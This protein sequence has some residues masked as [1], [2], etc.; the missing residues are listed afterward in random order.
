M[1]RKQR[2]RR[3]SHLF[4]IDAHIPKLDVAGS[5]PVS[6][7]KRINSLQIPAS[8]CAPFVLRLHHQQTFLQLVHNCQPAF[9][10]RLRIH[11]LVDI[12]AMAKLI[13]DQLSIHPESLH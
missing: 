13:G 6:R 3:L 8:P 2:H 4:T 11:V 9:D 12:E 1:T 10:W 5:N 7:S